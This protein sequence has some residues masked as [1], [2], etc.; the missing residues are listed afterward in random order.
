MR[1][2]FARYIFSVW[3]FYFYILCFALFRTLLL[4]SEISTCRYIVVC[5]SLILRIWFWRNY[6]FN[7]I[8]EIRQEVDYRHVFVI[9]LKVR[10]CM[11]N[12]LLFIT[13]I[14]HMCGYKNT[15][16]LF[17]ASGCINTRVVYKCVASL[18]GRFSVW[19]FYFLFYIFLC[20]E[21]Y[22]L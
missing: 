14:I 13:T 19:F 16:R 4:V 7:R 22:C 1:R 8:N 10:S 9:I 20:F 3:F 5:D 17:W 21:R 15:G 12:W 2:Q 11:L 6:G 18:E